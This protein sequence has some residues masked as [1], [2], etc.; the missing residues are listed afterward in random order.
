[1]Y[2]SGVTLSDIITELSGE[3]DIAGSIPDS[4]YIRWVNTLEQLIYFT[5][6]RT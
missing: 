1:M 3:V 2:N 4:A 5:A 6:G